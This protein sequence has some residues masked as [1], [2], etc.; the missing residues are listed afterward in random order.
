MVETPDGPIVFVDTAGM[1]RRSRIDERTEYYSFVRAL[2]AIDGS[3]VALL[4]IDATEGVT[5]QDQRL[6][7][8]IDAAGCPIVVL[9]NKWELLDDPERRLEVQADLKRK[10]YFLGEAPILKISALT[11]KG[12]HKLLPGAARGDR[13]VPPPGARPARSTRSIADAQQR[14]PGPRRRPGAVRH[15]GRHRSADVHPVRQPG[16]A[17]HVPALP[18]AQLREA[19]DFGATPI[20]LRVRKRTE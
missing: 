20:K 2:Q 11:G 8:R 13:G 15:A 1:R 17:A 14:Q 5:H 3:D 9:L 7:E 4:V 16:A 18:R 19:F 12:V 6:A 10:L